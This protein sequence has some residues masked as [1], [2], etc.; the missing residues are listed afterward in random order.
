[1]KKLTY[2]YPFSHDPKKIIQNLLHIYGIHKSL[3]PLKNFSNKLKEP[4]PIKVLI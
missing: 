4:I 1:M 3:A 2:H